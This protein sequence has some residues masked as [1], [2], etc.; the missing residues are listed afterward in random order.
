MM[1]VHGRLIFLKSTFNVRRWSMISVSYFLA[2]SLRGRAY[3]SSF[4]STF[5]RFVIINHVNYLISVTLPVC[6]RLTF[7]KPL[8]LC[9]VIYNKHVR[10]IK[11]VIAFEYNKN[12][13]NFESFRRFQVFYIETTKIEATAAAMLC[14]KSNRLLTIQLFLRHFDE[15]KMK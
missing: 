8:E 6:F 1:V 9:A 10:I 15:K 3:L 4:T 2:S 14:T 5:I 13:C 11:T 7:W 12:E